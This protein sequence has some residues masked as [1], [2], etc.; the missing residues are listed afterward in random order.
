[1]NISTDYL[2][3]FV[4]LCESKS[5]SETSAIVHK[6]QSAVSAQIAKLEQEIGVKLIHGMSREFRLTEGGEVFLTYAKEILGKTDDL[7]A[8]I[9]ETVKRYIIHAHYQRCNVRSRLTK[10]KRSNTD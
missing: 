3:T 2:K 9:R 5:F 7:G 4:A 1:M 6:S 10:L 8:S